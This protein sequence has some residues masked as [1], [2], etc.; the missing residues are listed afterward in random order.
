MTTTM[1]TTSA[2]TAASMPWS[3]EGHYGEASTGVGEVASTPTGV[4]GPTAEREPVRCAILTPSG[5]LLA[6]A[7]ARPRPDAL[8]DDTYAVEL[9][10]VQPSG[11]L[12]TLL[13]A[14]PEVVLRAPGRAQL[15]V[16]IDH[17]V[18]PRERRRYYLQTLDAVAP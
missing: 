17:I 11:A 9:S 13:R 18:G 5:A 8:P 15:A 7:L 10:Q 14:N 16:R 3:V 12:E 2:A 6:R 1:A 4:G